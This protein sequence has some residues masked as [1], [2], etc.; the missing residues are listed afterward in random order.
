MRDH[1]GTAQM[2]SDFSPADPLSATTAR[3]GSASFAALGEITTF[4]PSVRT[5]CLRPYFSLLLLLTTIFCAFGFLLQ[6]F[7]APGYVHCNVARPGSYTE[8]LLATFFQTENELDYTENS[9]QIFYACHLFLSSYERKTP[10]FRSVPCT[11]LGVLTTRLALG[12]TH[13]DQRPFIRS[14][15]VLAPQ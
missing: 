8:S 6:F 12:F 15:L 13:L 14:G 7:N 1:P 9:P 3:G 4:F 5:C 2:Y 10:W 11:S